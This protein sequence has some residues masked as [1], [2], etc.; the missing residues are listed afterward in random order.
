MRLGFA[1]LVAAACQSVLNA[2]QSLP[3]PAELTADGLPPVP[4]T[5][6]DRVSRY[7][8]SR[9]ATLLDWDPASGAALIA[10]RFADV[11]QIHRVARPGAARRQLTFFSDRTGHALYE[12]QA[13]KFFVF[14]K[15][16]G[17]G[18]FYQLYR[19]DVASGEITLLTDGKSRNTAVRWSDDGKQI[20]FSS[21]RRNGRD[22]DIWLMDPRDP[23]SARLVL[24]V[25]GGGWSLSDFSRDGTHALVTEYISVAESALYLVDLSSG[26]KEL[27]TS[28]KSAYSGARFAK[29][30]AAVWLTTELDSDFARLASLDL[31]S[32]E[33]AF[34]ERT[35]QHDVE[36]IE[37]S[38]G[39]EQ[40][41]WITTTMARPNCTFSIR[42]RAK[43]CASRR[44]Q[45]ALLL[46]CAGTGKPT[47][48]ALP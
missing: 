42:P 44:F 28:K 37:L 24:A 36:D 41:A 27:L 45:R 14:S 22:S 39:G 6:A 1:F 13:G 5:L 25:D 2:Q 43:N 21:T 33:L 15:D 19:Y 31:K 30:G 3:K 40:L 10:T 9:S 26:K 12:P 35:P 23:K 46:G 34:T 32:H 11:P 48:S 47:G 29:N 8:E 17:G 7:T 38:P 18:E 4:Q 20:A 16:N